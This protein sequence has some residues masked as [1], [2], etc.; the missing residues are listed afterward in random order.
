MDPSAFVRVC[1]RGWESADRA[2]SS[3]WWWRTY[4]SQSFGRGRESVQVSLGPSRQVTLDNGVTVRGDRGRKV[5][6]DGVLD[7]LLETLARTR[8]LAL[9][10]NHADGQARHDLKQVVDPAIATEG[11]VG[12]KVGAD[13]V[14]GAEAVRPAGLHQSRNDELAAGVPLVSPRHGLR[15][16]E[17]AGYS[18]YPGDLS[19]VQAD[20]R[21]RI[22][23]NPKSTWPPRF[24]GMING[25][26]DGST[27]VDRGGVS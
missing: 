15:L 8:V 1:E 2:S 3:K 27:V 23:A 12:G 7:G 24:V 26:A 14:L 11:G 16:G 5:E 4:R 25:P 22:F 9:R 19:G 6:G 13:H 20:A 10:L 17:A 21:R 18:G